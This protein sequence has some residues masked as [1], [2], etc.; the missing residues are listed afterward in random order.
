MHAAIEREKTR[1]LKGGP[2]YVP[3]Q[4]VMVL[5]GA[6]K[7][8]TSYKVNEFNTTDIFDFKK[9]SFDIGKNLSLIHI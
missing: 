7:T 1:I 3:S 2:I 9:L 6:K 8:G 5:R 4:W